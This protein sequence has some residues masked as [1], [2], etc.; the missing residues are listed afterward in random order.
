MVLLPPIEQ[1]RS[2]YT[3]LA[4]TGYRDNYLGLTIDSTKVQSVRVDGVVVTGFTTITGTPFQGVNWP[5]GTGTHTIDVIPQASQQVL[6]GA[7]VT[8]HG[9]DAYVSYGYTGG[10]DLTTIVTGVTP[11]G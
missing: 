2:R 7:G 9:Y 8:V 6:P 3:V 1:W 5:V 10:L 11:G 4:S